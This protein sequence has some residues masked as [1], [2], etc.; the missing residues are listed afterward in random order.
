M[1]LWFENISDCAY[2]PAVWFFHYQIKHNNTFHPKVYLLP[3][4]QSL[5]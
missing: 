4:Q 2:L 1:L 3:R 5:Q